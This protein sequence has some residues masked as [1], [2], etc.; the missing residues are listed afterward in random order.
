[1]ISSAGIDAQPKHFT[2]LPILISNNMHLI[3]FKNM[4]S[5]IAKQNWYFEDNNIRYL[6]RNQV[7]F[8]QKNVHYLNV[9]NRFTTC[10]AK[11]GDI[12]LQWGNIYGNVF[13]LL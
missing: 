6:N 7:V 10:T 12:S 1:M 2:F 11:L 13:Q 5:N 3:W 8:F 9:G 4:D